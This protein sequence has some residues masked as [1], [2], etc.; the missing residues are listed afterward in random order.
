MLIFLL[1]S[2]QETFWS[3]KPQKFISK[4]AIEFLCHNWKLSAC[5][6]IKRDVWDRWTNKRVF[7]SMRIL[8]TFLPFE[9][10][11]EVLA[12]WFLQYLCVFLCFEYLFNE[13]HHT[14]AKKEKKRFPMR[15]FNFNMWR[16]SYAL[17]LHSSAF[18]F[19][20][21]N[22]YVYAIQPS[23]TNIYASYCLSRP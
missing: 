15:R 17:P 11:D 13:N 4:L 7:F 22:N 21:Y 1:K 12:F 2:P 18:L 23:L 3:T 19:S 6:K 8:N 5:V 20:T 16:H 10:E 9:S 14:V